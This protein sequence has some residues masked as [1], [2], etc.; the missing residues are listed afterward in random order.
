V[1]HGC[2]CESRLQVPCNSLSALSPEHTHNTDL[3]K[4]QELGTRQAQFPIQQ[5]RVAT[6][7]GLL[8]RNQP[9]SLA[10]TCPQDKRQQVKTKRRYLPITHN[11]AQTQSYGNLKSHKMHFGTY[12]LKNW[13]PHQPVMFKEWRSDSR[14]TS[15]RFRSEQEAN[16][17]QGV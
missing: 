14:Y 12:Y 11:H 10:T 9:P 6:S 8:G 2:K 4:L 16:V 17:L 5:F 3:M 7:C 15:Q 1:S 13:Y